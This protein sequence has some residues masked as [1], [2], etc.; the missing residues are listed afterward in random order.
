MHDFWIVHGEW[1]LF[2]CIM[3]PRCMLAYMASQR[4]WETNAALCCLAW[5][6]AIVLDFAS[7]SSRLP[8]RRSV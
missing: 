6:T 1:F 2:G 8:R 3:V 4:F 5:A 7:A